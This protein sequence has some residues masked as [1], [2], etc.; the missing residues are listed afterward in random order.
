MTVNLDSPTV[1]PTAVFLDRYSCLPWGNYYIADHLRLDF[2][3]TQTKT[4]IASGKV[5][6]AFDHSYPLSGELC[7]KAIVAGMCSFVL[8]GLLMLSFREFKA[9]RDHCSYETRLYP[10]KCTPH[11]PDPKDINRVFVTS[12]AVTMVFISVY[13]L[14]KFFRMRWIPSDGDSYA[15]DY[16]DRVYGDI[17]RVYTLNELAKSKAI[18]LENKAIQRDRDKKLTEASKIE[19]IN[20]ALVLLSQIKIKCYSSNFLKERYFNTRID[21]HLHALNQA[22]VRLKSQ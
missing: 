12:W 9:T 22:L 20:H 4:L 7:T 18:Q 15:S 19:I 1:F 14:N 16:I 10:S 8:A 5:F 6:E 17:I 2:L 11:Y 13:G 21:E 3:P